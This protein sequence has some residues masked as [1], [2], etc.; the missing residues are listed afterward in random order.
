MAP[1]FDPR[2]RDWYKGAMENK[3]EAI[4]SDPYISADTGEMV[5]TISHTTKDG[6][7]V[8]AVDISLKVH[9]GL[10]NKVKIGN[11]GYA[12]LLDKNRKYIAHPTGTAGSEAKRI[13][14]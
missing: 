8:V 11:K 14:R 13:S 10:I 2:K 3:G 9:T 12:V 6:S 5:I 7:G 1:D 4:I